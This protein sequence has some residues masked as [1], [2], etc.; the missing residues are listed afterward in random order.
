MTI[1]AGSIGPSWQLNFGNR[2]AMS[3]VGDNRALIRNT[4]SLVIALEQLKVTS[5]VAATVL[6]QGGIQTGAATTA[7]IGTSA[8]LLTPPESRIGVTS[9][10]FPGR[11]YYGTS[12]AA[13][14]ITTSAGVYT[15]NTQELEAAGSLAA[16]TPDDPILIYPSGALVVHV[17]PSSQQAV[18]VWAQ[19]IQVPKEVVPL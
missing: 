18:G 6:I 11:A 14:G 19:A 2:V 15:Y 1:R 13:T 8:G 10:A 12:G 16:A 9:T 5:P 4:G 7:P 17:L 3:S